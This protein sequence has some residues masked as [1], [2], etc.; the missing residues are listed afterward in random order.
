MSVH[1]FK[2][3]HLPIPTGTQVAEGTE[4]TQGKRIFYI[5]FQNVQKGS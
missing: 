3:Q 5:V 4:K 2:G 1:N